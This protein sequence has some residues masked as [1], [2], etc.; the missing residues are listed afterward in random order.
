MRFFEILTEAKVGRE[1]NHLEDLVFTD[2]SKGAVRAVEILKGLEQDSSDVAIKWDGYPTLYWGRDEDGK[3]LLVGKNAWGKLKA[4]SPD[5]VADFI[6]KSGKGVEEEPWRERFGN[7]M[8]DL[9]P[10]F[11][12]ATPKN[13]RGF[14]Y[15]DLLFYPGKPY[16]GEDGKIVFTPNKVTYKVS[17]SSE[18]GRRLARSKVAV[19]A[20]MIYD[21][22]GAGKDS[23]KPFDAAQ[24]FS[25][26]KDIVVLGQTYVDHRPAVD[27]DNLE[28]IENLAKKYQNK[29]ASFLTPFKGLS[30]FQE[31]IYKFVNTMSKENRLEEINKQN[32][33]DYIAMKVSIPKQQRITDLDNTNPGTLENLF[34]LV[35]ELMKAK[36]EVIAKLDAAEADVTSTTGAEK[37]GEGYVKLGDKV[38]F[39][40][41]SRW[42]PT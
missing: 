38:K 6:K 21:S 17:V 25:G 42:K 2:P 24:E 34:V 13:F 33:Y 39:V 40:P 41:R 35:V 27:V 26:S 28:K 4:E 19:A 5:Q 32:F 15:G 7:E 1:F 3:F 29:I 20:T 18:L 11:E 16:E 22:F 14:V 30:D 10:I 31:I 23:G 36:D 37:G 8:A 12:S 9:W